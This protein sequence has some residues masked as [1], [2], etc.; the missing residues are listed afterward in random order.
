MSGNIVV[1]AWT[2]QIKHSSLSNQKSR[3]GIMPRHFSQNSHMS[4]DERT[5]KYE[6]PYTWRK[7]KD[8]SGNQLL[9]A[10][11]GCTEYSSAD[12]PSQAK[13]FTGLKC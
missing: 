10:P 7:Q 3:L 9:L 4:K 2:E 13:P 1:D 6:S 11:L 12:P 8:P 5:L